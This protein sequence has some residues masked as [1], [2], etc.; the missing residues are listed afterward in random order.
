M[1]LFE[2]KD[3]N[4]D[5]FKARHPEGSRGPTFEKMCTLSFFMEK[6]Q[7]VNYS[8]IINQPGSETFPIRY[9]GEYYVFQCKFFEDG[10]L[11][12]GAI[13]ESIKTFV[14]KSKFPRFKSYKDASYYVIYTNAELDATSK[15]I[16]DM[17]IGNGLKPI[18]INGQFLLDKLR[19]EQSGL[20][21]CYF[22][23]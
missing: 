11:N 5:K 6:N 19:L 8:K 12:S 7:S 22:D 18:W 21:K 2:I 15:K 17:L 4:W 3:I 10:K 9:K 13:I 1:A 20:A 14:E 16:D 23:P